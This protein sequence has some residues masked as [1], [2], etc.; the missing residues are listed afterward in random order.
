MDH[1]SGWRMY[2]MLFLHHDDHGDHVD[3]GDHDDH[4]DNSISTF[5][6]VPPTNTSFRKVH[7]NWAPCVGVKSLQVSC[8]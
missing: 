1:S 3:H 2:G 7:I 5:L 4:D 6:N 8:Q